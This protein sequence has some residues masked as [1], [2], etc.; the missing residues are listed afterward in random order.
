MK[1][2]REFPHWA[3]TPPNDFNDFDRTPER[4]R[5]LYGSQQPVSARLGADAD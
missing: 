4:E 1:V 3:S 2:S 5:A